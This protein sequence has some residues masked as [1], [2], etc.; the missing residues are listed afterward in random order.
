MDNYP[1]NIRSFDIDP[2]SPFFE[3]NAE[4]KLEAEYCRLDGLLNRDSRTLSKKDKCEQDELTCLL[5]EE[6]M[7]LDDAAE[8]VSHWANH[9]Q[10]T[11]HSNAVAFTDGLEKIAQRN[12]DA[13][14]GV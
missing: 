9:L 14:T 5:L 13:K 8:I 6:I 1:E 10:V 2:Y 12:L 11:Q 3:D 7:K 4:E